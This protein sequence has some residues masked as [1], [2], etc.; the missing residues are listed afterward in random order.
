MNDRKDPEDRDGLDALE[1]RW[2]EQDRKLDASLALNARLL[3]ELKLDK[4]RAAL[5]RFGWRTGTDLAVDAVLIFALV[6]YVAARATAGQLRFVVPGLALAAFVAWSFGSGV[7]MATRLGRVDYGAKVV[8]IQQQLEALRVL[9]LRHTKWIFLC[10]PLLWPPL[11]IVGLD[12]LGVDA[13]A[14]LGWR[15]ILANVAFGLAVIPVLLGLARWPRLARTKAFR[16]LADV[17]AG[18]SLARARAEL[19]SLA[20]FERE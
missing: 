20:A 11:F 3:R 13:Y 9:R 5:G 17:L 15:Y 2:A 14:T 10:A 8:A 6:A 7:W 19:A 18:K 1:A 16:G 4:T 12:L